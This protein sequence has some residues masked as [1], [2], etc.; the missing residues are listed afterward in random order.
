MPN[1]FKEE[2]KAFVIESFFSGG[3][4]FQKNKKLIAVFG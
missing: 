1:N 2:A 3:F 4:T